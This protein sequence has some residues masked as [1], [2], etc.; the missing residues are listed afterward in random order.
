MFVNQFCLL[1]TL[2]SYTDDYSGHSFR[3]GGAT[4]AATAGLMDWELQLF[5]RWS[6]DAYQQY[7][8]TPTSV[9]VNFA[10]RIAILKSASQIGSLVN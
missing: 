9:M 4:D 8:Q 6:S 3:R 1:L 2:A 5:G 7:I 10:S